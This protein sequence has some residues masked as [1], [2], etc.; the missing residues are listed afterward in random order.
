MNVSILSDETVSPAGTSAVA[1]TSLVERLAQFLRARPGVWIDG[2]TLATVAGS[3]A[4]RTRISELRRAPFSMTVE[5]RQRRFVSELG[6]RFTVS[7]YR[8]VPSP[9]V[10]GIQLYGGEK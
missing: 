8:Y 10:A 1:P 3:Y 6:K 7:D 5:N 4:W 2:R 9:A